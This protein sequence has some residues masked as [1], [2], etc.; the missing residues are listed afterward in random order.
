MKSKMGRPKIPKSKLR[1]I[2][3]QVRV[4][5]EE[6]KEIRAATAKSPHS[7]S[8]WMRQA[9]LAAARNGKHIS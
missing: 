4:S 1:D 8:E 9:L 3:L 2:L 5:L 6:L 7:K